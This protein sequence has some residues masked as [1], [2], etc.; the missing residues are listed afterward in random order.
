MKDFD[1]RTS[2]GYEVSKRYDAEEARGDEEKRS[3]S[4]RLSPGS[5]RHLSLPWG[6]A[7]SLCLS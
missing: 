6:P 7:G 4:W 1:P 3:P 5:T 2:F